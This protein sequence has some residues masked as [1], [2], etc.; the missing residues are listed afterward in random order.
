MGQSVEQNIQ[1]RQLL[2]QLTIQLAGGLEGEAKDRFVASAEAI[3]DQAN[4]A[5]SAASKRKVLRI[6]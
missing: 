1:R 4:P 6:V 2:R 3:V 5:P